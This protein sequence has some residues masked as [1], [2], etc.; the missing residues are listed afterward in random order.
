MQAVVSGYHLLTGDAQ[1]LRD[2]LNTLRAVRM[3]KSTRNSSHHL[4][5]CIVRRIGL[6]YGFA[7]LVK[8]LG[9]D[10]SSLCCQVGTVD[11]YCHIV[12]VQFCFSPT[13]CA[14]GHGLVPELSP[15]VRRI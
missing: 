11:A 14:R 9:S 1:L 8:Q 15:Y 10:C 7:P 4:P 5:K 12:Y 13:I 3:R 6:L 2:V